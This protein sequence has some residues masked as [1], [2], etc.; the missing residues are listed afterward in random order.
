VVDEDLP[1]RQNP[2]GSNKSQGNEG[3]DRKQKYASPRDVAASRDGCGETHADVERCEEK[4][5][6]REERGEALRCRECCRRCAQ[7][8]ETS[9]AWPH[10]Y[11]CARGATMPRPSRVFPH[12]TQMSIALCAGANQG[13]LVRR[14]SAISA[15][16]LSADSRSSAISCAST[17]G[18]GKF[19]ES[20]S[21]SS[22]SQERSRLTL[23]RWISSS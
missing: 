2:G 4:A 11:R 22:R 16:A 8:W 15:N 19:S 13:D 12:L 21:D 10:E 23:S 20:S 14:L 7:C 9:F 6:G 5:L 3:K 1:P 18:G 17:S